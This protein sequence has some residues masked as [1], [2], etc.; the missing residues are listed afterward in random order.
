V[1]PPGPAFPLVEAI[2]VALA[3][4]AYADQV[5]EPREAEAIVD[6]VASLVDGPT[7]GEVARRVR[8]C[9]VDGK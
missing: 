8:A 7:P 4:V 5:L 6:A 1:K 2:A 9:I 3:W